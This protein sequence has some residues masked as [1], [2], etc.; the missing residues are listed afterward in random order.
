MST[1]R[2]SFDDVE[3]RFAADDGSATLTARARVESVSISEPAE[4]REHV[5]RGEDFF[6]AD[7]YP[8]LTF[9]STGVE[10]RRRRHAPSSPVC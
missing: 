10:L 1:F 7:A 5:V 4:F 6:A 3:G 2:A 9:R 8:E